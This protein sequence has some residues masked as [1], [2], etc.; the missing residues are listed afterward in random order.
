MICAN[1]KKKHDFTVF[2]VKVETASS[3]HFNFE[4]PSSWLKT[5]T[6]LND[7]ISF[8]MKA[9]G[10]ISGELLPWVSWYYNKSHSEC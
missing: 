1:N 8:K 2:V 10:N 5:S 3:F 4:T 9:Y 6:K 7:L